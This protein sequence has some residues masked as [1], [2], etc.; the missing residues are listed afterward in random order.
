MDVSRFQY[1]KVDN[2]DSNSSNWNTDNELTFIKSNRN[3]LLERKISELLDQNPDNT[4]EENAQVISN[5]LN[6]M[7]KDECQ[8]IVEW[9]LSDDKVVST[10]QSLTNLPK[11]MI[12]KLI[13]SIFEW[14]K[15]DDKYKDARG[16]L[17][18]LFHQ[19][20][21]GEIWWLINQ[22]KEQVMNQA[23][24]AVFEARKDF[25]EWTLGFSVM[26]LPQ[27]KS[28]DNVDEGYFYFRDY[29]HP[30]S[31]YKY[32]AKEWNIY[33]I[34]NISDNKDWVITYSAQGVERKLFDIGKYEDL[35]WSLDVKEILWLGWER[36]K[37]LEDLK[38]RIYVNVRNSIRVSK[39]TLDISSI[40]HL[41]EENVLKN[42]IVFKIWQIFNLND[43]ITWDS[44]L[45]GERNVKDKI[46][47]TKEDIWPSYNLISAALK[48]FPNMNSQELSDFSSLLDQIL[49][50][51]NYLD[52]DN[53]YS[54]DWSEFTPLQKFI[55]NNRKNTEVLK[56]KTISDWNFWWQWDW[57]DIIYWAIFKTLLKKDEGIFDSE[58]IFVLN[59]SEWKMRNELALQDMIWLNY[60]TLISWN[61]KG[62]VANRIEASVQ[63]DL[64]KDLNDLERQISELPDDSFPVW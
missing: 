1:W 49:V 52:S 17:L 18:L 64:N 39:W 28:R 7:P 22:V 9:F 10:F 34:E 2:F 63:N 4:R 20:S 3:T 24:K 21:W 59:Y 47:I 38:Q 8:K 12:P 5:I 61:S 30:E 31:L 23:W 6:L 11:E 54:G 48:S 57:E 29:E 35:V 50:V 19:F 56:G 43:K 41:N 32:N 26:Q 51:K 33:I 15:F 25:L 45:Q 42:W 14:K 58:K 27:D 37:T 53:T 46:Q 44:G 60:S 55:F 62:A 13:F 16:V 36:A 40:R